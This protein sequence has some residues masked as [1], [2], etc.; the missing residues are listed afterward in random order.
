MVWRGGRVREEGGRRE[1]KRRSAPA[2]HGAQDPAVVHDGVAPVD[3]ARLV[4]ALRVLLE[5]QLEHVR[6]AVEDV[7]EEEHVVER[8]TSGGRVE[9]RERGVARARER[10]DA[11]SRD[12]VRVG[13]GAVGDD[14][15]RC[16]ED[17]EELANCGRASAERGGADLGRG[18]PARVQCM[19]RRGGRTAGYV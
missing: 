2:R 13:C 10:R 7:I 16:A 8:A 12:R 19:R 3:G 9:W 15:V 11:L 18:R 14:A 17:A 5:E 1:E 4:R 6:G